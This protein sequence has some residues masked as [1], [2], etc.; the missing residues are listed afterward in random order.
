MI[1][2]FFFLVFV[3]VFGDI[4]FIFASRN[5]TDDPSSSFIL[6]AVEFIPLCAFMKHF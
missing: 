5:P 4:V 3:C 1:S 2:F 6:N